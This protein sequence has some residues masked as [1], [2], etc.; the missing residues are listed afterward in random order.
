MTNTDSHNNYPLL[1]ICI[2]SFNVEKYIEQSLDSILN[3]SYPNKEIVIVD[4]CSI[5]NTVKIINNWIEKNKNQ[6]NIIFHKNEKNI[7]PG[8]SFWKTVELANWK[9][10]SI[11]DSDDFIIDNTFKYKIKRFKEN[12]NLKIIYW[13]GKHY[14]NWILWN[15]VCDKNFYNLINKNPKDILEYI[16]ENFSPFRLQTTIIDKNFFLNTCW[17]FDKEMYQNDRVTN[18]RIFQNIRSKNEY[19]YYDKP[20]FAYRTHENNNTNNPKMQ[21]SFVKVIEK[22]CPSEKKHI[23]LSNLYYRLSTRWLYTKKWLLKSLNYLIKSQNYKFDIKRIWL[24]FISLI[25]P[26]TI[27][28]KIPIKIKDNIKNFIKI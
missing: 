27:I 19:E 20:A 2:A 12:P 5:D 1:S 3:E 13:N 4:D 17:W 25:T 7:W 28:K 15:N 23:A 9:Y 8:G 18:I 6:I 24:Y 22:Y 10:I 21:K 26:Q 16:L 11:L 14:I